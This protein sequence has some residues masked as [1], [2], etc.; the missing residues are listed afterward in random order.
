M[1]EKKRL[2]LS[3]ETIIGKGLA[4]TCYQHPGDASICIKVD[5]FEARDH[6]DTWR[7][8]AYYRRIAF[9]KRHFSYRVI[10]RFY[11]VVETSVGRGAMFELIRD[12]DSGAIAKT[13]DDVPRDFL[14]RHY[15]QITQGVESLIAGLFH[16]G[17]L[18]RDLHPGNIVLQKRADNDLRMVVIDGIG[19]T[20]FIPLVD[21]F[22]CLAR[23][24]LR[25]YLKKPKFETVQR[26][27]E[28]LKN[29]GIV[30]DERGAR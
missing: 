4:R 30:C 23:R 28:D 15:D 19:H 16:D 12:V 14:V 7:E 18:V 3:D 11:G 10:P 29:D 24:K 9:L 25:R 1:R 8:V 5:H 17:I 20:E 21:C 27:L 22:K 26:F 13:L 6:T 2:Q